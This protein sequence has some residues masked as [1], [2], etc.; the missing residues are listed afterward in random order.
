MAQRGRLRRNAMMDTNLSDTDLFFRYA[1]TEDDPI[2]RYSGHEASIFRSI[3]ANRQVRISLQRT[4]AAYE[5]L[6]GYRA[7]YPRVPIT[8]ELIIL[9]AMNY[10]DTGCNFSL[11]QIPKVSWIIKK[12]LIAILKLDNIQLPTKPEEWLTSM[13]GFEKMH[14][15]PNAALSLDVTVIRGMIQKAMYF[16]PELKAYVIKAATLMDSSGMYRDVKLFSGSHL[17][18]DILTMWP[19]FHRLKATERPIALPGWPS[20][21]RVRA[22][23]VRPLDGYPRRVHWPLNRDGSRPRTETSDA[24]SF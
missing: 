3:L 9:I 10:I 19:F 12:G 21:N 23:R 5:G 20:Y 4:L 7:T 24:G 11:W 2:R 15:L 8:A 17:E 14:G 13:R 1:T 22:R 18:P 6:A 16:C